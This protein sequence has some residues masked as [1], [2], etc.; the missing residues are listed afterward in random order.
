MS[1]EVLGECGGCGGGV[2][3]CVSSPHTSPHLPTSQHTFP[4]FPQLPHSPHTLF[5]ILDTSPNFP[6]T[7]THFLILPPHFPTPSIFPP[8]LTQLLK[9][10]KISQFFHHPYSPKFFI[11]PRFFPILPHTYFIINPISIPKFPTLLIAKFSPAIK[12]TKN[13]L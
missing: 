7:P 11:L 10:L 6:H 9:L 8:Y 13:S 4:H 1:G 3:E 12:H 5:H 2:E